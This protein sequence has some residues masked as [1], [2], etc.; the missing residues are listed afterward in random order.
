MIRN[1]AKEKIDRHL[2]GEGPLPRELKGTIPTS[3]ESGG[4]TH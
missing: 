1:T 3:R 4:R 2:Y